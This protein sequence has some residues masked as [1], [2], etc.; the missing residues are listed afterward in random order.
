MTY[1]SLLDYIHAIPMSTKRDLPQMIKLLERMGN[2]EKGLKI[3]HVGGT[4]GKG[5]TSVFLSEMLQAS[6]YKV[7]LFTSPY[8]EVFNERIRL[9]G[10]NIE[11]EDLV[12]SFAR[13]KAA[14]DSFSGDPDFHL[15]QFD[16]ITALAY[17]Y[18]KRQEVDYAVIEVGLGGEFDSTNTCQP[19]ISIIGSISMDHMDYLGN[20]LETISRA[21]AGIIKEGT[22]LVLYNQSDLVQEIIL[23]KAREKN[24]SVYI[25]DFSG[26]KIKEKSIEGQKFDLDLMGRRFESLA[27]RMTG[28]HQAK[29]FITAL[30]C[31]LVLEKE[32][33]I[34]SL[35]EAAIQSGAWNARWN[36]RT[37]LFWENP[38]T[39][40]DGAHN[41]DG[42]KML[43]DYIE[44]Y[45]SDYR[46]ILIFGVLADKQ[47]DIVA[48][49][50][51]GHADYL[52]LTK[53]TIQR[54][55]S[56]EELRE[57]A[58]KYRKPQTSIHM[59]ETVDEAVAYAQ[60]LAKKI[61][62]TQGEKLA[63]LYSGS[64][65]LIGEARSS[66]KKYY[67]INK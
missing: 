42:S 29:N 12:D 64:L 8:L 33:L 48:E 25:T 13:V 21:K 19:I 15:T 10:R 57:I 54:A 53:P 14:I 30:I 7:G 47:V 63:V 36:G 62:E 41:A 65:Y 40:L 55:E 58:V 38:I 1:N 59:T 16:I 32:G 26:L 20:R 39:I 66:L 37:E 43:S 11:D 2:P 61:Q 35:D 5:S 27:I 46:L 22:P 23:A 34:K 44:D 3:I 4:N 31:L 9:N 18:F 56:V 51:I 28:Q 17:D 49:N 60:A 45:L 24:A 50:L 6:G 67:N 52:V